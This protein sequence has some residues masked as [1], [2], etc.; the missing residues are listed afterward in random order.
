MRISYVFG[1]YVPTDQ[2][3]ISVGADMIGTVRGFR[4]FTACRTVGRAIFREADHI[5]RLFHAANAISM[6]IPHTDRQLADILHQTVAR[7]DA[8]RDLL[9]EIIYTGGPAAPNGVAPAGPAQLIVLAFDLVLPPD[10]WY[11]EGVRLASFPHLRPVPTVKLMFYLG[12]VMAHQTVVKAQGAHEA[13]FVDPVDGN[14]I[15]EGTTF[16]FFIVDGEGRLRTPPADGSILPGITRRVVIDR[17]RGMGF[18][19]LETRLTLSDLRTAKA[20]FL[21]SSTRNVVPVVRVDDIVIGSGVPEAQTLQ[22]LDNVRQYQ[23]SFR[24]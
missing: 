5:E 20:A 1:E 24:A 23:E 14:T 11:T 7:N 9:L 6:E 19:V 17:A 21:T 15:L 2:V 10:A 22:L 3:A 4:I 16:N 12:A 8:D 13:L 18:D